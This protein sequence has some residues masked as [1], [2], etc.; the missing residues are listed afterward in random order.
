MQNTR[1][2]S[3]GIAS[4]VMSYCTI[5][6]I[7]IFIGLTNLYSNPNL[8]NSQGKKQEV[9][10]GKD[11][12]HLSKSSD[13]LFSRSVRFYQR[14]LSSIFGGNCSLYPS[15]SRYS[16]E[17]FETTGPL[18]GFLLTY[19]RLI[20]ETDEIKFSHII[21]DDGKIKNYDPV[22]NNNF[23]KKKKKEK[24]IMRL[25]LLSENQN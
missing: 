2:K 22:D 8:I 13:L 6:L 3:E 16:I 4:K 9:K 15:C 7:I 12:S 5:I 19:D 10:K 20:H 21:L 11:L 24:L 23:F 18:L 14:N 1:I 25:N 17:G